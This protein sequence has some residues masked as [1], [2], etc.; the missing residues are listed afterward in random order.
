MPHERRKL[1]PFAYR[2]LWLYGLTLSIMLVVALAG[3]ASAACTVDDHSLLGAFFVSQALGVPAPLLLASRG[4]KRVALYIRVS[5]DRQAE[6]GRSPESQLQDMQAYCRRKGWEVVAVYRDEGLSGRLSDRPGLQQL[7]DDVRAGKVDVVIVYYI[8]RFYR[9]LES[10]LAA[11][12][13][14][15]DCSVTFVSIHENI[16]FTTRWG[17]LILN[18]L[19]T[20]AEIYVDELSE[21]TSRGKEQRARGGLYNGSIPTGYCNGLCNRCTDPN[22]P[23]YC[24]FVGMRPIGD[25]KVPVP[26]PIESEAIRLAF[27]WY[28]SGQYSDGD[29]AY[30]LNRHEFHFQGEIYR[31]RPKRQLGHRDSYA[32]PLEFS[33]D[34]VRGIL[35]RAFYSGVVEYCGGEGVADERRRFKKAQAVYEGQHQALISQELFDLTQA[36]RRQRGHRPNR[37]K[38]SAN[39]RVYPLSGLLYSWPLRS[40][41]RAVANGSGQRLY[42]DRANIG[43]SRLDQSSRSTQPTVAADPLE[44]QVLEVL[45]TLSLPGEWQ[46]R[47]LA[48]LVSADG[49]LAD[50]ERQRR[51]LLA[52]FERLKDLYQQGDRTLDQ[53]Q[54]E[55]LRLEHEMAAL[56]VPPDLDAGQVQALLADLPGLWQQATPAE[57]K[58]LLATVFQRVY[59]QGADIVRL[60]AFPAFVEHLADPLG[61]VVG[62]A[63]DLEDD[64]LSLP[65]A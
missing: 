30:M 60:V 42:R 18:I 33:N 63:S 36:I 21:T 39:E 8:N 58:G 19:G 27:Q 20:L 9:K 47:I 46:Q 59:V 24:P 14:L 1:M 32:I 55:K 10:L 62:P 3:P 49:G 40:K 38:S 26:H 11:M 31:F 22:G 6:E 51:H 29:I 57:L 15:H 12:K 2:K 16:D 65:G 13:L 50:V 54:Q 64:M 61:R 56:L 52:Q 48:Y 25:G 34:T 7:L 53:Y 28:A 5:T 43:K 17:K 23:G 41:M 35:R 4:K 45:D 37:A 44:T